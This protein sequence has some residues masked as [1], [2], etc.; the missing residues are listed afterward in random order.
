MIKEGCVVEVTRSKCGYTGKGEALNLVYGDYW[1]VKVT[2]KNPNGNSII[3]VKSTNLRFVSAAPQK[4][5]K[6]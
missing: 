5:K 4:K 2:E 1:L 3:L 6:E